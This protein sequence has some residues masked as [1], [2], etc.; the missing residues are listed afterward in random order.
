[1]MQG[2]RLVF[3]ADVYH[4]CVVMEA[5]RGQLL[6][7]DRKWLRLEAGNDKSSAV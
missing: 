5:R 7:R 3:T 1:M 4:V 2:S 6:P